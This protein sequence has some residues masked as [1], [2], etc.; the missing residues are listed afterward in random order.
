MTRIRVEL[1]DVFCGNTEDVTGA[2]EF[3]LVGAVGP[4][5]IGRAHV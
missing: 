1:G 3:Y 2:D 4:L 5:E